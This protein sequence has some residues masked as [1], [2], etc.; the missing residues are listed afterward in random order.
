MADFEIAYLWSI[1]FL[2]A[3]HI[4]LLDKPSSKWRLTIWV[5][6][7]VTLLYIPGML[8]FILLNSFWQRRTL[9]E[10]LAQLKKPLWGLVV[11]MLTLAGLIPFVY[12]IIQQSSSHFVL[13]WLGLPFSLPAV[14]DILGRFA[15]SGLFLLVRTPADPA[16]WLGHLPLLGAFTSVAFL[17][18][19]LFYAKHFRAERTQ[20]LISNYLLAAVLIAVGNIVT[21][22]VIVPLAYTVVAGGVAYL[23]HVW[24]K[25]FPRNVLARQVGIGLITIAVIL[26][27]AYNL[28]HYFVAWPHNPD[29]HTAFT[30][31]YPVK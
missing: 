8:W 25:T 17:G 5:V 18:G 4:L 1:P 3:A 7:Q 31:S 26:A 23:L 15:Y 28:R 13:T 19:C 9:G 27:G 2:T 30:V 6:A 14:H 12:G 22:S 10:A 24:L 11:A 20:L 29:T 16:H 21:K